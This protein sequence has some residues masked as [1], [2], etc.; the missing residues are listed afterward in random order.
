MYKKC[1]I[2]LATLPADT[3]SIHPCQSDEVFNIVATQSMFSAGDFWC[4]IALICSISVHGIKL[5]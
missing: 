1:E 2:E 4:L 3:P 5:S